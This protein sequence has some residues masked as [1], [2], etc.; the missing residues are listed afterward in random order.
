MPSSAE[1]AA[2]SLP[3]CLGRTHRHFAQTASTNDAAFAWL[4]E[5]PPAPD[6]AL[7]TADHQSA[8]RGRMGRSW[9]SSGEDIYASVIT[10]PGTPAHPIG[11]LALAVGLALLEGVAQSVGPAGAALALKWPNDLLWGERKLAGILCETRWL[12]GTPEIVIGFGINVGRQS[13]AGDLADTAT[14]LAREL[15]G[16][17]PTRARILAAVLRR[18]EDRLEGFFGRGFPALREAYLARWQSEGKQV[19]VPQRRPDG[20]ERKIAARVEGLDEDGA[21][22]VRSLG[23]G[24]SFRVQSADVWLDGPGGD[25]QAPC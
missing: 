18:L 4:R 16:A 1:L 6:G 12:G 17:V 13:F 9:D 5:T 10:I 14:S 2:E 15:E 3:S 19:W 21:L 25:M 24:P 23:G 8:G 22:R 20:S 7:V 11:A